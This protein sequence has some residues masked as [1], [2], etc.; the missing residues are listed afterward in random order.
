[1]LLL[2]KAST[3][4][5]ETSRPWHQCRKSGENSMRRT[6]SVNRTVM[7][8]GASFPR[9]YWEDDVQGQGETLQHNKWLMQPQQRQAGGGI[10]WIR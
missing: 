4:E 9:K 8:G 6:G 10:W 2:V 3:P 7:K 1:M 5:I